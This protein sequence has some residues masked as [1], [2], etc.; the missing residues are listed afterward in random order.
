MFAVLT[1]LVGFSLAGIVAPLAAVL[2]LLYSG[3]VFFGTSAPAHSGQ[4]DTIFVFDRTFRLVR[5]VHRGL[6]IRAI[7]AGSPADLESRCT[8]S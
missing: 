7:L 1:G 2:T 6:P 4:A 3:A 8:A 5:L